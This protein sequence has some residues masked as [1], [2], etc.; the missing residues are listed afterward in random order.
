MD[1]FFRKRIAKLKLLYKNN[2]HWQLIIIFLP[3]SM[4]CYIHYMIS[5]MNG[6][7]TVNRQMQMCCFPNPS[8]KKWT[9]S[10]DNKKQSKQA[11]LI[12]TG[13]D[14]SYIYSDCKW[15]CQN[16]TQN[17][18]HANDDL[19]DSLHGGSCVNTTRHGLESGD[20]YRSY[21]NYVPNKIWHIFSWIF[22]LDQLS[23]N[24]GW[25]LNALL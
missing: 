5:L 17:F 1:Y 3:Y 24:F 23:L 14:L 25:F 20:R 13:M 6:G 11:H 15:T 7:K 16:E 4:I 10:N 9:C 8:Q 18:Q 12:K 22:I 19:V 21:S 2:R